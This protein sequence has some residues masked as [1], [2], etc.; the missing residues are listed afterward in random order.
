M[1]SRKAVVFKQIGAKIAYYRTLRGMHQVVLAEKIGISS[2]VL[3]RI[4]RGKYN[5]NVSV[6]MLLDIAEGLGIDV[7]MLVTFDEHEKAMWKCDIDDSQPC[8]NS[9]YGYR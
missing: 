9:L 1:D 6:S 2:S 4:E 3:S 5:E 8:G 7:A